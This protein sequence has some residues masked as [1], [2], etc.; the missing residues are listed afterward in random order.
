M[1]IPA[2]RVAPGRRKIIEDKILKMEKEGT[3]TKSSGPWFSPIVLVTK[4]DGT[5]RFC[6]DY[7][8]LNDVT[9]KDAYLLPRID[10]ILDALRGAKYFCSIDLASG[11]WQIKVAE[12]DREENAFG[13]HLGLYEFL[14]MSCGLTG[15]PATFS[16][17]MDK[18][19]D[20]LIGKKCLVYLD[21]V[22]IYGKTFE[23]T[24]ANLKL[25]MACLQEHN[26]VSH[27]SKM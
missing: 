2:L 1:R 9:H 22:I 19:L 27:G 11:Y 6:V 3:I 15:A 8:K 18:V 7:R 24:L 14:C 5:I 25:V 21:D 12:K 17:L 4:K 10:D 16:R 20:G 23:E 26:L 13:S